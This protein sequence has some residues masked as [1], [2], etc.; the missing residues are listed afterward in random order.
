MSEQNSIDS[1]IEAMQLLDNELKLRF[2]GKKQVTEPDNNIQAY[3]FS[4]VNLMTEKEMGGINIK[5]GYTENIV[6]YR[7]NIGFTVYDEFR[8]KHYSSRSCILLIPVIATLKMTPI[9]FT[10]NV[11]NVASIRNIE[12]IG[13]VYINTV[14]VPEEYHTYYPENARIKRRYRWEPEKA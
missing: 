7:G 5:V 10:C 9:W 1:I 6:N 3:C 11:D 13:A 8:G 14:D 12:K 2:E 4:M